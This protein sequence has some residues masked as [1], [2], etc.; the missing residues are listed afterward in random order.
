MNRSKIVPQTTKQEALFFHL[1][2][3]FLGMG[4]VAKILTSIK[5]AVAFR[6][7]LTYLIQLNIH[8]GN[9]TNEAGK[10]DLS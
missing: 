9:G 1:L 3:G 7:C 8:G 6:A 2:S 5:A 10:I 4:D